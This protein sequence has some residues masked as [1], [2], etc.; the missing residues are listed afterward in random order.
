MNYY[1][2]IKERLINVEI[3]DRVKDYSKERNRVCVYFEIGK[4]LSEAGKEYGKNIVKKYS[5]KLVFEVGKKYNART[6]RS[7]RQL[8]ETFNDDIW[9]PLVSKL[10]WTQLLIIMPIKDNNKKM[11]YV[12]KCIYKPISKRE[13]QLI[14][15]SKEYERL[16]DATKE[17]IIHNEKTNLIDL[18]PNPIIIKNPNK[19]ENISEK[20]LQQIIMEDIPS[21]LESLG[22]GYTFIKNEYKI[23][24]GN[25]CYYIIIYLMHL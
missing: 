19:Y 18:I 9:K 21:F 7:M 12:Q 25:Q 14:I 1:N 13:L 24:I 10:S 3:Y 23:K 2:E 8:Y 11:Y 15:K 6:L 20:A 16:D 4:L 5:D 17:K 22:N